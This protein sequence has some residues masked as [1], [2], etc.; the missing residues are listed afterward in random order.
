MRNETRGMIPISLWHVMSVFKIAKSNHINL[1]SQIK[2]MFD[3]WSYLSIDKFSILVGL[4]RQLSGWNSFCN[5]EI[6][7]DPH[8]VNCS[9]INYNYVNTAKWLS[10]ASGLNIT[11]IIIMH[12]YQL[13]WDSTGII[14]LNI[15]IKL[16]SLT[17]IL[18]Y[19]L[20]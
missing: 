19:P 11:W 15:Y 10:M 12:C 13:D 4:F 9:V 20:K 6:F 16:V 14:L 5:T 1:T 18:L 17:S 8:N 7:S 3:Q 2:N